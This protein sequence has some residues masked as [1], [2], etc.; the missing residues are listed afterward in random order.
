MKIWEGPSLF[1]GTQVAVYL[2]GYGKPSA[3]M[4]T[5]ACAQAWVLSLQ[6]SPIKVVAS[7]TDDAICGQCVHR[8]SPRTCYVSVFRAPQQVHRAH[9]MR[10][11]EH[12][13]ELQSH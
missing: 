10:S 11:E 13:S 9:A 7:R 12:T 4:K 3:N 6:D 1:T 5:G 2:T 8:Q